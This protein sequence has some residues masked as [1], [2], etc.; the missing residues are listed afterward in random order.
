L[1]T[2]LRNGIAAQKLAAEGHFHEKVGKPLNPPPAAADEAK[3]LVISYP[4]SGRTWLRVMMGR[5][6]RDLIGLDEV[7]MFEENH[8]IAAEGMLPTLFTHDGSSN[9][10]GRPWQDLD[11]DKSR[12]H[13]KKVVYLTRDPRDVVVS[14]YFQATRRK[15]LFHGTISEFIRSDKYGI[16]KIVA[17]N[18][19]WHAARN[20]PEAFLLV[21]YEDLHVAPGPLLRRILEFMD[22]SRIE[23][24]TLH[25][26]IEF[27]SFSNMKKV[28]REGKFENKKLRPGKSGDEESF[29]VR[30][31]KVGGFVDYLNPEDCAF[32]DQI[33]RNLDDPYHKLTVA[34]TPYELCCQ[35]GRK[36]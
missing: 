11:T 20:V 13:G 15:S 12:Y 4:K 10:E 30:K 33:V 1:G 3:V 36:Q 8:I 25:R 2:R 6:L 9:T 14:C 16:R 31:G 26:A 29:K 35:D 32:V 24:A 21:R 27:A 17:F 18:R 23:D 7:M 5:A 22:V 28:E 34:V 19:I